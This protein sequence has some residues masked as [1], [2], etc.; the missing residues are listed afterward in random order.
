MIHII[1]AQEFSGIEILP[2][3]AEWVSSPARI[4]ALLERKNVFG[5]Y[6]YEDGRKLGFA[7]L[8]R[9][10]KYRYFLWDFIINC[11]EQNRGYGSR[12]LKALLQTMKE[13]R[14]ARFVTTT[15]IIGNEHAKHIYEKLGFVETDTVDQGDVHEIN[16]IVRL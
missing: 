12:A 1:E 8:R 15:Y 11:R 14:G 9:Y 2:G 3:Q 7:L 16:M 5:F 6:F 13:K 4:S 10:S